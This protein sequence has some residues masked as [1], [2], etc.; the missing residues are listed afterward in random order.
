MISRALSINSIQLLTDSLKSDID[1]RKNGRN[2]EN[3]DSDHY[4]QT[5]ISHIVKR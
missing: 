1:D 3:D 4:D 2:G 5:N